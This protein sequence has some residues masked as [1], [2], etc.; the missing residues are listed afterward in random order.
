MVAFVIA[1][2]EPFRTLS[3]YI[4]VHVQSYGCMD[5]DRGFSR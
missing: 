4:I 2:S 3:S 5:I 1:L